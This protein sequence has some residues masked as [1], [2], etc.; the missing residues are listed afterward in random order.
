MGIYKVT[1]KEERNRITVYGTECN[2]SCRICSLKLKEAKPR[3][4]LDVGDVVA[5][6]ERYKPRVV[7]FVGS[8]PLANREVFELVRYLKENHNDILITIGHSNGLVIPPQGVSKISISIKAVTDSVHREITGTTNA[9]ILRNFREV[10]DAGIEL[11]ASSVYIPGLV[12]CDE[13]ERICR[14]ISEIDRS[15]S[16]HIVGYIPVPGCPW[17]RPTLPEVKKA[18]EVASR[19]LDVITYSN[20]TVEEALTQ[21]QWDERYRSKVIAQVS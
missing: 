4:S 3:R 9:R 19:Y 21:Q 18:R 5:L 12:E 7:N 13:I 14:F 15:I 6:I 16:Y 8:E 17:R 1:Y 11:S 20:L 10:Y 2:M